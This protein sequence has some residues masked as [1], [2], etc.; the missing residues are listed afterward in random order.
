MTLFAN[1][2]R[3]RNSYIHGM[4]WLWNLSSMSKIEIVYRMCVTQ[5]L[6]KNKNV[7]SIKINVYKFIRS[8]RTFLA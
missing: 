7:Y 1:L 4:Y 3:V 8:K 2:L 5:M 6:E